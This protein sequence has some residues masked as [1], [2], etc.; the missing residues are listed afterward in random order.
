MYKHSCF[1]ELG[2]DSV[3][4]RPMKIKVGKRGL[5]MLTA[6]EVMDIVNSEKAKKHR[7]E[8]IVDSYHRVKLLVKEINDIIEREAMIHG[9]TIMNFEI[10]DHAVPVEKVIEY[11]TALGY[12]CGEIFGDRYK[13]YI[14][15]GI[16]KKA[17]LELR[18]EP[19]KDFSE[20]V[21]RAESKEKPSEPVDSRVEMPSAHD[22]MMFE[23][24]T[25]NEWF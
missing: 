10:R 9:S 16:N 11:Y 8:R 18:L 19:F 5:N 2:T 1:L 23:Q 6:K 13:I 12:E 22:L 7:A 3:P 24:K 17:G 4:R 14:N 25:G 20:K 15:W 21:S